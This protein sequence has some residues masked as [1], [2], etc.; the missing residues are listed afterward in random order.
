MTPLEEKRRRMERALRELLGDLS[1]K[2]RHKVVEAIAHYGS[3]TD[4]PESFW[5]T[6]AGS[7]NR[8]AAAEFQEF[9]RATYDATIEDLEK[10]RR[11]VS[12]WLWGALAAAALALVGFV[13]NRTGLGSPPPPP[14]PPQPPAS[15]EPEDEPNPRSRIDPILDEKIEQR[16]GEYGDKVADDYAEGVRK[17]L[18]DKIDGRRLVL[19]DLD[20]ELAADEVIITVDDEMGPELIDLIVVTR[21]TEAQS[22]TRRDAAADAAR[23]TG[24]PVEEYWVTQQDDRV[25]PICGPLHDQPSKVWEP[26]F[27]LG[28]PGHVNCRCDLRPVWTNQ[29]ATTE[30]TPGGDA[31]A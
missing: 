28:P 25:C 2:Y 26:T 3:V 23:A 17:R 12:G 1:D 5:R 4:V 8:Q 20:P 22:E 21:S 31:A 7:V 15:P 18:E 14:E 10:Q 9:L 29:P 6:M 19:R 30:T 27:P 16:A 11:G 24:L 13:A